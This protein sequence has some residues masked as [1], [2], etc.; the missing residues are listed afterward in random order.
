MSTWQNTLSGNKKEAAVFWTVIAINP[1]LEKAE[2]HV[3]DSLSHDDNKAYKDIQ[4][5]L[6]NR[7]IIALV[8]GNHNTSTYVPDKTVQVIF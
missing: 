3:F 2:H 8:K 1:A 4:K 7:V 5:R 6:P